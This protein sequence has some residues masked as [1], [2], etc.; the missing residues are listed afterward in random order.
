[1]TYLVRKVGMPKWLEGDV[2]RSPVSADAITGCLR[3]SQNALSLW[4]VED[5]ASLSDA[6]LALTSKFERLQR[7]DIVWFEK[8]ELE[9]NGFDLENTPGETVVDSLVD[10]HVDITE[11][12]Y[13]KLGDVAEK[14]V[15]SFKHSKYKRFT[16]GDIK[17][18]I[19]DAVENDLLDPRKLHDT[20]REKCEV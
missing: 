2:V 1:M 10:S 4:K 7:C 18:L 14:V 20:L 15:D 13:Q 6:V 9:D 17:N 5:E 8:S 19:Q 3:T 11:L 16:N 12:D